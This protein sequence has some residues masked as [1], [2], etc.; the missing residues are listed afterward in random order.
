MG[1]IIHVETHTHLVE[2]LWADDRP[3]TEVSVST[4][5]NITKQTSMTPVRFFFNLLSIFYYCL[6]TL[7]NR[8]G[9]VKSERK[10]KKM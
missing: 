3:K 7:Y 2:L 8:S 1:L 6:Y 9:V 4:T 10:V 5:H